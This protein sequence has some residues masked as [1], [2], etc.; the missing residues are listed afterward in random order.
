MDPVTAGTLLTYTITVSNN[1]PDAATDVSWSDTLPAG[2]TFDSLDAPAGW[3]CTLPAVGSG[4]TVS[5]THP[6]L[7]V[8]VLATFELTVAVLPNVTSGTDLVNTA[9]VGSATT[10]ANPG[11]ES[12]TATTTVVTEADL[13][14]TKTDGVDT[15]LA[16]MPL[17]YTLGLTN[18]G[19]SSA[20]NVV[21]S[22]VLPTGTTFL[23]LDAP[24]GWSCTLPAVGS[25]GTVSC[26][27]ASLPVGSA[28][29]TL[30]VQVDDAT[31]GGT[32]IANLATV[33]SATPDGVPGGESASDSVTVLAPAS[34]TA[35]KTVSGSLVRGG[36]IVYTIVLTNGSDQTQADN[37]GDELVD[38]LPAELALAGAT[39]TTG[40]AIATLATNT[41]T[42]NGAIPGG[43][44]VTISIEATIFPDASIE[45]PILNQGLIAF[46]AD[47]NGTN[48]TAGVTDD[49][50]V[51]GAADQTAFLVSPSV[52][53]IPAAEARGLALLA[54]LLTVVALAV[55]RQGSSQR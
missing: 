45:T 23:S 32:V 3:S 5:C 8:G 4:G 26:S 36:T 17:V 48:E 9:T 7:P 42:W 27:V 30:T 19:P 20:A 46:D 25:G 24:A 12:G 41:V 14:L 39:A 18:A 53:E 33:T 35:T 34:I 51:L 55:L 31:A 43:G 13:T 49:P 6:S 1:G 22:D 28:T 2:T 15:T 50:T 52:T 54:L 37:A 47:G 29:F 16:G 44:T 11:D 38:V 10:E 40:T 21:L